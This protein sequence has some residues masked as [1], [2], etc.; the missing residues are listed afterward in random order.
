[1]YIISVFDTL[2]SMARTA[3]VRATPVDLTCSC[4]T[5]PCIHRV[6]LVFLVFLIF[7]GRG[8]GLTLS[9]WPLVFSFT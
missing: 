7:L 2:C 5:I 3:Y 6:F 4:F 8:G 9:R 1:M